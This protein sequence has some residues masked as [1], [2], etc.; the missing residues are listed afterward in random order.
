MVDG[1]D[2]EILDVRGHGLGHVL[3]LTSRDDCANAVLC[4][5][6]VLLAR[7]RGFAAAYK[8]PMKMPPLP[9]LGSTMHWMSSW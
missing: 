8:L 2:V 9:S 7:V 4:M 3:P 5:L 6:E 1:G